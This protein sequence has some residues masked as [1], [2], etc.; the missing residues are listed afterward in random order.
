MEG[1][2]WL[3]KRLGKRTGR[4]STKT[5]A[6]APPWLRWLCIISPAAEVVAVFISVVVDAGNE[7]LKSLVERSVHEEEREREREREREER[8]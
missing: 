1:D 8:E 7:G 2:A 5:P 4:S 3:V 6:R